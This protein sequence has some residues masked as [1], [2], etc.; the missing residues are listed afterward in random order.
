[1]ESM[2]FECNKLKEIKGLNKFNTKNVTNI[3]GM[4]Y[5]CSQLQYMDLSNFDISN[6]TTMDYSGIYEL[7]I[8]IKEIGNQKYLIKE[9]KDAKIYWEQVIKYLK[10]FYNKYILKKGNEEYKLYQ[11]LLSN[12]CNVYGKLENYDG[13]INFANEGLEINN[14]S[15]KLYYFRAKAYL[16]KSRVEEAKKDIVFLEKIYTKE[17]KALNDLKELLDKELKKK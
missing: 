15:Q 4:F 12:L 17:D 9:Y 14:Q 5:G 1:M 10:K 6:V 16:K 13:V 8:K 7:C 2:F 3:S 11:I